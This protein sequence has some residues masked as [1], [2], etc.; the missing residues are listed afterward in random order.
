MYTNLEV[1][2]FSHIEEIH[3]SESSENGTLKINFEAMLERI[4]VQGK[5]LN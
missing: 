5:N 4:K 3:N 1:F 2:E